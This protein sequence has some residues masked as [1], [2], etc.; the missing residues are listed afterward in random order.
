MLIV[1]VSDYSGIERVMDLP[2]TAEQMADFMDGTPVQQAFPNL[3]DNQREFILS[4]MTA[5]EWEECMKEE[6]DMP[7]ETEEQANMRA[8]NQWWNDEYADSEGDFGHP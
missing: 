7:Q 8:W 2:I 3:T 4:G 6:E 1:K 5:E